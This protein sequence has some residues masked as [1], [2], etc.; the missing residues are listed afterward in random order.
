MKDDARFKNAET[1]KREFEEKI[2]EKA[3]KKAKRRKD[4]EIQDEKTTEKNDEETKDD[5]M[6][7]YGILQ[8]A[9]GSGQARDDQPERR[10]VQMEPTEPRK[11]QDDWEDLAA[12]MKRAR[13]AAQRV[14][15]DVEVLEVE[16]GR[17]KMRHEAKGKVENK[18]DE[19]LE[20]PEITKRSR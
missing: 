1:R 19:R 15:L 8:G 17:R 12:R 2:I 3:D 16:V 9:T 7:E 14:G 20:K 4:E 13:T 11:A 6:K 10:E 5:T 18:H